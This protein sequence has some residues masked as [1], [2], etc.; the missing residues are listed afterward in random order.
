MRCPECGGGV[1][2]WAP[3]VCATEAELANTPELTLGARW[4]LPPRDVRDEWTHPDDF[5]P[6]A[7]AERYED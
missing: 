7:W 2:Y 4:L 3:C 1:N 5:N 6:P